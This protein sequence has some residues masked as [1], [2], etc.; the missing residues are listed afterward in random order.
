MP[1]ANEEF[2]PLTFDDCYDPEIDKEYMGKVR[3][4][5]LE[6]GNYVWIECVD[7]FGHWQVS[8]KKGQLPDAL[9]H[10]SFTTFRDALTAVNIWLQNRKVPIV[11]QTTKTKAPA[12]E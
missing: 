12:Q 10:G 8:L 4:I 1:S 9:K 2:V 7:P 5:V 6:N 3:K 11:Y